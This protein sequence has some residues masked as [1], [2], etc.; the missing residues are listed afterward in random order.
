V[1]AP[2]GAGT[3]RIGPEG[4][5][6]ATGGAANGARGRS[7]RRASAAGRLASRGAVSVPPLYSRPAVAADSLT[8]SLL[9]QLP[10]RRVL[11]GGHAQCPSPRA[12]RAARWRGDVIR[13]FR[14]TWRGR[15]VHACRAALPRCSPVASRFVARHRREAT[16]RAGGSRADRPLDAHA[17]ACR[18]C[19]STV[20]LL[21]ILS[22]RKPARRSPER[23]DKFAS[24]SAHQRAETRD[25][26][27]GAL[28]TSTHYG[29]LRRSPPDATHLPSDG[30]CSGSGRA[31]NVGRTSVSKRR[32]KSPRRLVQLRTCERM[33]AAGH[34]QLGRHLRVAWA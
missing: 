24:S 28:S 1:Y 7:G 21:P 22:G 23:H 19:P 31:T 10:Q 29:P 3:G 12:G 34:S 13:L 8:G 9:T 20:A 6:R 11:G 2:V 27:A 16:P 4:A 15:M 18:L 5:E 33:M 17:S 30:V 32:S 14:V 25:S 26:P